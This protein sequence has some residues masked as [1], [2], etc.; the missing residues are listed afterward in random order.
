MPDETQE[1]NVVSP[2]VRDRSVRQGDIP[3]AVRRRYFLDGRGGGGLGFYADTQVKAPAFRDQGRKLATARNDPNAIRDMVA[4]AQHR[5]W[6]IVN[7][8]GTASFRRETWLA[9]RAA[10]LEVRG[11]QPDERDLQ[12]LDRRRDRHRP[13]TPRPQ[14][15]ATRDDGASKATMRVVEAVIR[16]RIQDPDRQAEI[17]RRAEERVKGLLER[18]ARFIDPALGPRSPAPE[19]SRGR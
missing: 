17:L 16:S 3:E 18:G 15:R 5:G 13:S 4:I 6:A 2:A 7:V 12:A 10:G 11:Y 19:R 1:P 8:S 14:K 9:S